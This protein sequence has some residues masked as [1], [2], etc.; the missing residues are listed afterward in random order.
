MDTQVSIVT[1]IIAIITSFFGSLIFFYYV[2]GREKK[3]RQRIAE[4]DYEEKFLEKISRGNVELLR[5]AFRSLSFALFLVFSSG[6]ALQAVA[7]IPLPQILAENIR[8]FSV[9]MWGAAAAICLS[10]F[11]SLVKLGDLGKARE[12]LRK[13]REKLEGKL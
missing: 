4:L 1:L 2:R 11:R 8:F 13:K 5:S 3:I 7:I 9:A 12:K 6:A 10:Y